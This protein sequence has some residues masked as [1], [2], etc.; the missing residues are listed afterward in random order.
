M[1]KPVLHY[2]FQS[3]CDTTFHIISKNPVEKKSGAS[4]AQLNRPNW[5]AACNLSSLA[6]VSRVSPQN[7]C[8]WLC[9]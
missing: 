8:Y 1:L 4:T 2:L 9:I 5:V 6:D 7:Q 3:F